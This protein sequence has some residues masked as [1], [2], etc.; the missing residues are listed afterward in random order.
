[1]EDENER[2]GIFEWKQGGGVR[3]Q[4]PQ[5]INGGGWRKILHVQV[6]W[7]RSLSDHLTRPLRGRCKKLQKLL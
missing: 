2:V 6:G 4:I 3:N 1:V 5:K 7:I